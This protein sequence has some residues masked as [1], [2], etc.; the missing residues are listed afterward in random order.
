MHQLGGP[1][2]V[3]TLV[4]ATTFFGF[5]AITPASAR[6]VPQC[7]TPP[8]STLRLISINGRAALPGAATVAAGDSLTYQLSAVSGCR[9][10]RPFALGLHVQTPS[11]TTYAGRGEGWTFGTKAE[12]AT[13]TQRV[14]VPGRGSIAKT[15]TVRV[16]AGSSQKA[17]KVAATTGAGAC[18]CTVTTARAAAKPTPSVRPVPP[19][20]SV[21]A[22]KPSAT[23]TL[24]DNV[25]GRTV[26]G[27]QFKLSLSDLDG[28]GKDVLASIATARNQTSASTKP[29]AVTADQPYEIR[30]AT[31]AGSPTQLA[32]YTTSISCT[33]AAGAAVATTGAA[34]TWIVSV[35]ADAAITC[36]VNE[37][38]A[39]LACATGSS[40]F[41]LSATA[42]GLQ[43]VAADL[44]SGQLTSIGPVYP[45]DGAGLG[46]TSDGNRA[47]FVDATGTVVEYSAATGAFTALVDSGVTAVTVGAVDPADGDYYFGTAN[48][49]YVFDPTA[50]AASQ[51][52]TF[53]SAPTGL[54]FDRTGRGYVVSGGVL[55]MFQVPTAG[56][57]AALAQS[58]LTTRLP[59]THGLSFG[60]D[61]SL[62]LATGDGVQ[63]F[64]PITGEAVGSADTAPNL[65]DLTGCGNPYVLTATTTQPRGV[66]KATDAFSAVL[67][68]GEISGTR[69]GPVLATPGASYTVSETMQV[70]DPAAYTISW[71]CINSVDGATIAAGVGVTGA[72]AI[73]RAVSGANVTCTFVNTA[74]TPAALHTTTTLIGVNG[75]A[76]PAAGVSTGD[77]LTYR[78]SIG[79]SGQLPGATT[80][81]EQIPAGANYSGVGEGW[82]VTNGGADQ[83]FAVEPGAT[84]VA[85]FTITVGRLATGERTIDERATTSSGDCVGCSIST[86]TVALLATTLTLVAVN[87]TAIVAGQTL[88]PGDVLQYRFIVSN[89]GGTNGSTTITEAVPPNTS[90]TGPASERWSITGATATRSLSAPAGGSASAAFTVTVDNPLQIGTTEITNS[91]SVSVGSCACTASASVPAYAASITASTSR[92]HP[93][94]TVTYTVLVRNNGSVDYTEGNPAVVTDDLSGLS[95]D[96]RYNNDANRDGQL[97]GDVVTWRLALPAGTLIALTFTVTIN[98]PDTGD[99]QLLDT[100]A[101]PAGTGGNC[102]S[103]SR[104]PDCVANSVGLLTYTTT[105]TASTT[106]A[107]PGDEVTYTV[108]VD[109][110]GSLA[111]VAPD[112]ARFSVDLAGVLDDATF[113]NNASGGAVLTGTT[114]SWA[115]AVPAGHRVTVTFAVLIAQPDTGDDRLA[116]SVLDPDGQGGNCVP[117]CSR[118]PATRSP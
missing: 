15:F 49:L 12:A 6:A 86:A 101:T 13:A 112:P 118:L 56:G 80:V 65:I 99:E 3:L 78:V 28:A 111:Y 117:V 41:G 9:T 25:A 4:A 47:F 30:V 59:A 1:G 102:P 87:G 116:V 22:V 64:D 61:G 37:V 34:P 10:G 81:H 11:G 76:L 113:Q 107:H 60:V 92:A 75:G 85:T 90:Y 44:G 89:S 53:T 54:A 18:D 70:D 74:F 31:V 94:D 110:T 39:P 35:A 83:A 57:S 68:G 46:V 27:D 98:A 109:N 91:A 66:V 17:I 50:N 62:Y 8:V 84:V 16:D 58:A 32:G 105:L 115:L 2:L 43:I 55:S 14:T 93:G 71:S 79:N 73:G 63:R 21:Q 88:G 45:R 38:P 72:V 51:I 104:D 114:L 5:G 103:G 7:A 106:V 95:D 48:A 23:L 96:A 26:P 29:T 97:S 40:V 52:G 20:P 33:D 82:I 108:A 100:I 77:V 19:S 67:S 42:D 36:V 24:V 69:V